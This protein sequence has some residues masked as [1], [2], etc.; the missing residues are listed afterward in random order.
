MNEHI[1]IHALRLIRI[2]L[3][4]SCIEFRC[5][6]L[7]LELYKKKRW[8]KG[9]YLSWA[10]PQHLTNRGLGSAL[11]RIEAAAGIA[12]TLMR[13]FGLVRWLMCSASAVSYVQGVLGSL[14]GAC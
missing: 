13:E 5:N 2:L 11:Q 6:N 3:I 4:S 9:S 1:E 7:V 8:L 10:P 14:D 12:T